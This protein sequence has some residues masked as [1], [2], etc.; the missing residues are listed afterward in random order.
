M[1]RQ[2]LALERSAAAHGARG[3]EGKPAVTTTDPRVVAKEAVE[4]RAR[5]PRAPRDESFD[6]AAPIPP[7]STSLW[8]PPSIVS[9][10]PRDPRAPSTCWSPEGGNQA[11][12]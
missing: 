8:T 7:P 1:G 12:R 4:R 3:R 11:P 6:A 9:F 2:S 5:P 10:P